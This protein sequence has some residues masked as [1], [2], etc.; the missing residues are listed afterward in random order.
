[1]EQ[2]AVE[3]K[4]LVFYLRVFDGLTR[5]V[6]G[7]LL[8]ISSRGLMLV[9]DVPVEINQ[10]YQLR[11]K[12]PSPVKDRQDIVVDATC[13]WCKPEANP[14]FF[15]AGFRIETLEEA[16]AELIANLVRDFG[17]ERKPESTSSGAS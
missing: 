14:D 13:M 7:Y 10:E 2:R 15:I 12:L 6:I 9:S 16:T 11:M 5:K 4:Y 3:R 8:D 1:M 17:F